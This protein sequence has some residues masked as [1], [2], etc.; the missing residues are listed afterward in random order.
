MTRAGD[1]ARGTPRTDV[2]TELHPT[3]ALSPADRA[4]TAALT[5]EAFAPAPDD[6]AGDMAWATSDETAIARDPAGRVAAMVGVVHRDGLLDGAPVRLA[7]IGGVA[8]ATALRRR[9]YARAALDR[10]LVA[11]D[12]RD[13]DLTVL[14][15]DPAMMPFYARVGFAPFA[16]TTWM[17]QGGERVVLDLEPT[18]VRPGRL[19]A[20]ADGDLDLCGTPW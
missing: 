9:G 4:A 10:A 16:G 12:A 20:P 19:P 14:I 3:S 8:T 18:M 6:P 5:D 11:V 17:E 7:G 13:P 1:D 2:I 15:C